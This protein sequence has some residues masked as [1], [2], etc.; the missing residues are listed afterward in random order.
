MPTPPPPEQPAPQAAPAPTPIPASPAPT[1][2]APAKAGQFWQQPAN[3]PEASIAASPQIPEFFQQGMASV[4]DL[5][6]PAAFKIEPNYLQLGNL[7]VRSLFVFTYPR[8][9]QTNWLS[10]IINYDITLDI[11]MFIYP[12]GTK[13]MMTQLKKESRPVGV[14]AGD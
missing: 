5:I 10:P 9:V 4:L 3:A 14:I 12:I 2:P 11:S 1:P 6:A 8:Y 13:Q 7:Y